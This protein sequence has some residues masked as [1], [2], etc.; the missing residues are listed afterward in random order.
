MKLIN[1]WVTIYQF[2]I[3]S[4]W[5]ILGN[6]MVGYYSI[7]VIL[8]NSWLLVILVFPIVIYLKTKL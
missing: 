4:M 6:D 3:L 7:L 5:V 8:D 2:S 1:V